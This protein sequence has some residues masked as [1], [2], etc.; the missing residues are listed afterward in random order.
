MINHILAWFGWKLIRLRDIQTLK[1]RITELA[2]AHA[3]A[4]TKLAS[5]EAKAF[6]AGLRRRKG[7]GT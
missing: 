6:R 5:R 2:H 1:T 3:V 4:V 7:R